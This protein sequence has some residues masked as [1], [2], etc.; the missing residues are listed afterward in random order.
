MLAGII[1]YS[2]VR[3]DSPYVDYIGDRSLTAHALLSGCG[4]RMVGNV[5]WLN[6]IQV[7]AN[8]LL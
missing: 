6:I 8:V 2:I 4:H 3:W 1:E 5:D 7:F